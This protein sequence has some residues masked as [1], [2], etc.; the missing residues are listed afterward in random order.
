MESKNKS[1]RTDPEARRKR[2]LKQ[3]LYWAILIAVAVVGIAVI[4]LVGSLRRN[5]SIVPASM[6][7]YSHQDVTVFQDGLLY[8]DGS[9][10]HFVNSAGGIEWSY[11]VGSGASFSVSDTHMIVWSGAQLFIVDSKGR[12]SFNR[13]MEDNIQFARIGSR[14][15]AIV[16]GSDIQPT[17]YVKD[18]QGGHIDLEDDEYAGD[19][20]LDCGFYGA[21]D[22]YLWTL[23]YDLY[24][25]AITTYLHTFQVGHMNTGIVTISDH[26][27][28]KVIYQNNRLNL[29]TTQQMYQ[30]DYKGVQDVDSTMLVYGWKYLGHHTPKRGGAYMLLAPTAQTNDIQS[31]TELRVLSDTLD[32]RYTLP[33]SCVGAAIRGEQI[34][35]FSAD[36]LYAG[37]ISSQRFVPYDMNLPDDRIVTGFVGL[38]SDGHAIVLSNDEVYSVTLPH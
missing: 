8:Y 21:N 34:F 28:Y 25:P 9:S 1:L 26:L 10:I 2:K 27:A 23:S 12:P 4:S 14:Y 20:I 30:Y 38:T 31:I 24:N 36:Y 6:P 17:L 13:P 22:E 16:V 29:F 18:M 7:C 15:A 3:I 33:A 19:V 35:A 5:T 32:R 11:P 37:K